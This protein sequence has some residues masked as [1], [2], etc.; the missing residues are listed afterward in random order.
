MSNFSFLD[1]GDLIYVG[2]GKP[3]KIVDGYDTDPEQPHLYHP[4]WEP[5]KFRCTKPFKCPAGRITLTPY[6]DKL[7]EITNA[8]KCG[9]CDVREK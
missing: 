3:P 2:P 9:A 1:N 4:A 6:C 5:C 8:S 7:E